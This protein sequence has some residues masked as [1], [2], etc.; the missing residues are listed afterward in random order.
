MED[1]ASLLPGRITAAVR[2]VALALAAAGGGVLVLITVVTDLS[3]AGRVLI[4]FGLRPIQGDYEIVEAGIAFAIF[5]FMPWCQFNRR[6]VNVDVFTS[7]LS[8]DVL[9][10]VD[11]LIDIAFV[12]VIAIIIWRTGIGLGDKYRN[13]QSTFILQMPVWWTYAVAMI[14]GVAWVAVSLYCL[15][16][17]AAALLTRRSVTV[18]PD[19]GR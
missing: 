4:P 2:A 1:G 10:F 3:I 15:A 19:G 13:G 7:R 6:H 17:S 16:E 8:P 11:F 5:A 18:G 12:V 14:G 9:R